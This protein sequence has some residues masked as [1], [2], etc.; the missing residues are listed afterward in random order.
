MPL[1]PFAMERWQ[2]TYETEV[3]Y[4]LSESGVMPVTLASLVDHSWVREVLARQPLGYGHTRGSP[5]LRQAIA[6][7][8]PGATAEH[9]LVTSGTA[10][11]NFLA[12]WWLVQPGDE[13]VL[14][15]PNYMQIPGLVRGFGG[16]VQA[17]WLQANR[18]WRPDLSALEA[19]VGPRTKAIVVCNP[20]NPSGAVLT[21]GE[22]DAVVGAAAR[23]GAWIVADEVYRGAEVVGPLT[24]TFWGRYERVL[25]TC[26]LSKAYGLP[27][28]RIGWITGPREVIADLWARHDYTTIGP[29]YLSDMLAR[30]ALSP[31]VHSRL[32]QRT[33]LTLQS[34]L[35]LLSAWV[36]EQ[37]GRV[38]WTPPEAGAIAMLR[39]RAP[40]NSTAL[41]ER[42][43]TEQ[44]VL[45]VPG[46][47]FG[48]DGFIR[49]GYGM[50]A[51][52][53]TEGLRRIG[54]LLAAY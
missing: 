7:L 26:G 36:A 14:L 37:E 29:A 41:A 18:G 20:N 21:V 11:A 38:G 52:V 6:A 19:A 46:D 48:L 16:Q 27:G 17:C 50:D 49:V 35:G 44:D 8:Y 47:H 9:V 39:Y 4:N 5:E 42:L 34:N 40:V 10:E 28:L 3:A 53:L 2:S 51:H 25:V 45:V 12:T 31:R 24:P 13:V 54:A 22:M 43:R 30:V 15:L 32:A 33:R 1:E 23:V